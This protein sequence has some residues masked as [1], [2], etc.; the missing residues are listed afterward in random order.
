M[1][2]SLLLCCL[3]A[4]G[5]GALS[6]EHHIKN[7]TEFI[8]FSKNV[9]RYF[10]TTVFLDADIDFS[11][12]LSEQFEPIGTSESISFQGTFDGQGHTISN[13]VV[14]SSSSQD[15]GLFGYSYRRTI[16]NIVLDS[17]CS[18]VSSYNNSN[19]VYVGGIV[20]MCYDCVI[21]NIVNMAS[22]SFT[23]NISSHGLWFGGIGGF[24]ASNIEGAV[25][26]CANYGSVTHSGT[27][28]YAYIGGVV[29][30]TGGNSSG[31]K[32]IQN[33]LNYGAVIHSGTTTNRQIVS[34]RDYRGC[35]EW[36][37]Q[38]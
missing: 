8:Q 36:N 25:R 11:G 30:L 21:E 15:V 3:A 16:K 22:V 31:K 32:C 5:Q 35:L 1:F 26:N 19:S 14:N 28:G 27:V 6:N 34:W 23:G 20:G 2:F 18:I 38:H 17:S 13:L 33:C 4:L 7:T 10:G 12:G 24:F 37:K 29:G 9:A